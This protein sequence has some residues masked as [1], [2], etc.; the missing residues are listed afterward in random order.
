MKLSL[1][2][3]L[4]CFFSAGFLAFGMYN[5]HAV[6][7]ITEGGVLGAVLLLQHWL[8]VSPA[9]SSLVINAMCYFMGWRIFGKS[10]VL[11][12]AAAALGYSAFY[13]L[14]E[15]FPPIYPEI[16]SMPLLASIVGS[17]FVGVGCGLC[18][19][20]GGAASGDDALAMSLAK[21]TGISIQWIYLASDTV[22]L[23]L[24]LSYIPVKRI[25]YSMLTVVL[26]GQII[27]LLKKK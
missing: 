5:I 15:Q 10:F 9:L 21:L 8:G 13:S 7:N 25:A 18:V 19:H 6:A 2:S 22:V 24:S 20:C 26:S 27:G 4:V 23:L 11:Y 3:C 17:I 1:R 16:A 12:S 14:C